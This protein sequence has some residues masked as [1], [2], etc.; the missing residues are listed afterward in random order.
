MTLRFTPTARA[1]FLRALVYIRQ[2]NPAAAF[3]FRRR[4]EQVL[5]RLIRFPN[6]GRV[7]PEFPD[8]QYREVIVPPYRFFY[9]TEGKTIWIVSVWHGAQLVQPPP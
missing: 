2:N 5:K 6:S 9:R 4:A 8:L 1:Q 3:E 7:I